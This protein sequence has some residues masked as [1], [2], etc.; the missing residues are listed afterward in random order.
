MR[1]PIAAVAA[2]VLSAGVAHAADIDVFNTSLG[3]PGTQTFLS[4]DGGL[5]V[6]GFNQVD[7][8]AGSLFLRARNRG[9][10]IPTVAGG[11]YIIQPRDATTGSIFQVEFQ[12]TPAGGTGLPSE[13][14]LAADNLFLSIE[15]DTN[16]DPVATEYLL[17]TA[18]GQLAD[19]DSDPFDGSWDDGGSTAVDGVSTR[20]TGSTP[21]AVAF[22]GASSVGSGMPDFVVAN[23]WTPEF[24]F[25]GG[26]VLGPGIYDIRLTL[27]ENNGLGL[28]GDIIAQN[29]ITAQVVPSPVAAGGGLMM[30]GLVALRRRRQLNE[31]A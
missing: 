17:S 7:S 20:G 4:S 22:G 9:T 19:A 2:T 10:S 21:P 30:M 18:I 11:N 24:G 6:T 15:F 23:S 1:L 29:V 14:P 16:P 28:P 12:Y 26:N 13:D 27:F 25:L 8:S 3:S 5:G 31:L